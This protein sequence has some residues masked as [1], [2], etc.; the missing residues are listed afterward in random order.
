MIY[1][2]YLNENNIFWICHFGQ[3]FPMMLGLPK[4]H[5]GQAS[6]GDRHRKVSPFIGGL[7]HEEG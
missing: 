2:I 3:V 6:T 7:L 1:N 4:K 5:S